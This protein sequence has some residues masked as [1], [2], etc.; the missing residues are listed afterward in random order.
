MMSAVPG[1]LADG[2]HNA[3]T[4][5][6]HRHLLSTPG[7]FNRTSSNTPVE[8]QGDTS[9]LR[10]LPVHI[11]PRPSGMSG[12]DISGQNSPMA[13]GIAAVLL[14]FIQIAQGTG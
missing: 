11:K 8:M 3:G 4:K 12:M 14:G 13:D 7:V 2:S 9:I 5:G 10:G 1:A 6:S